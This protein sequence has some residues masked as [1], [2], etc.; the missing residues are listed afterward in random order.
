VE[1]RVGRCHGLPTAPAV[2]H[3]RSELVA[4]AGHSVAL[5]SPLRVNVLLAEHCARASAAQ[6]R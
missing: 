1:R 4:K 3:G 5:E 2:T 6:T